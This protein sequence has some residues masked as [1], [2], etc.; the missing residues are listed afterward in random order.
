MTTPLLV[1]K[2][3]FGDKAKLVAAVQKLATKDLWLEHSNH[4]GLEHVSNAKLLR[5]HDALTT[6]QREFGT[7]AKLI[8]S[9]LELEKRTKDDGYRNR[10]GKYPLPRLLDAHRM[11]S[12]R[13]GPKVH[14]G[15]VTAKKPPRSKKAK[16][17]SAK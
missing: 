1:L 6:A 16:A 11:A 15:A 7:R 17:K 13:G 14:Q 5:L 9:I 8:S 12:R 10:L 3:R 2:E 4:S